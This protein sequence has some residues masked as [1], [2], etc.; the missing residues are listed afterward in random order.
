MRPGLAAAI[1]AGKEIVV[2]TP[3]KPTA[4]KAVAPAEPEVALAPAAVVKTVAYTPEEPAVVTREIIPQPVFTLS[5][6]P[7]VTR[8][9]VVPE[10][11]SVALASGDVWYVTAASVNVRE[12]PSTDTAVVEKLA[13]GEAVSVSFDEGS[14][15]ARVTIQGDG[16]EGYIALRLLSPDAP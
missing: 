2:I 3:R 7:T 8:E 15:W 14:E 11:A 4:V 16:V 13:R 5:A 10:A 9:V 1:A 6:L 12:G